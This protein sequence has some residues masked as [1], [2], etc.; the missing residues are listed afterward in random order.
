[1]HLIHG[2]TIYREVLRFHYGMIS[3]TTFHQSFS[4]TFITACFQQNQT[5]VQPLNQ[6]LLRRQLRS[7]VTPMLMQLFVDVFQLP[8]QLGSDVILKLTNICRHY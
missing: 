1:M 3:V 6:P 8:S 7:D 5:I 4:L 2:A